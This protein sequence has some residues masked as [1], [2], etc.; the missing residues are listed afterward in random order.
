LP[1]IDGLM[2]AR[3][4]RADLRYR[5]LPLLMVAGVEPLAVEELRQI[6][7][8]TLLE[9]PLYPS[10]LL[11][12]MYQVFRPDL[13]SAERRWT[14]APGRRLT[15]VLVAE[16]NP[17]NQRLLMLL[18][19]NQAE[20]VDY[21]STG[22]DAVRYFVHG[23]YDCVLMDCQMPEMDGYQATRRIREFESARSRE[24]TP[25]I[26]M[27]ANALAG[28]REAC[29]DAGMDEYLSKPLRADD[30]ARVLAGLTEPGISHAPSMP[31][32][33]QDSWLD[34]L[35]ESVGAEVAEELCAMA[36]ATLGALLSDG[37]AAADA[38]DLLRLG[39]IAHAANGAAGALC[40]DELRAK[41]V[42]LEQVARAGDE[43]GVSDAL[44]PWM[45]SM[46]Q[47]LGWLR[48][49]AA[50]PDALAT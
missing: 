16:D 8:S 31:S 18:L 19:R 43:F 40:L 28:D 29:L 9:R 1:G 38:E 35:R 45:E 22:V 21:V 14:I 50:E 46:R 34:R 32:R 3:V 24:R 37:R 41:C 49:G 5:A 20:H 17:I 27:T 42:T 12:A 47:V 13:V 33:P 36:L 6:G 25:I 7:I 44:T 48:D 23:S 15:R 2:L 39:R 11:E 10:A 4:L 26:A 30:L